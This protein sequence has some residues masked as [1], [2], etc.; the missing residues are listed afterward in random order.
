[1]KRMVSSFVIA[2][3]LT[4]GVAGAQTPADGSAR[5]HDYWMKYTERLPIG[6]TVRVRTTDG[7]RLTAVLAIVDDTGVTLEL[8]TRLPE[9]PRHIPFDELQQLELKQNGSSVAKTVAIGVGVGA[10]TFFG[11][12]LIMFA[13]WD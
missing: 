12:L 3:L 4:Y 5:S 7:R 6:S 13:A 1:M 9:P 10:S 11:I 8:K 2:T